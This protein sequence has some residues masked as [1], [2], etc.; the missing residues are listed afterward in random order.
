MARSDNEKQNQTLLDT[1]VLAVC[2]QEV[3]VSITR[4]VPHPKMRHRERRIDT[5]QIGS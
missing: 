2:T 5:W 4:F 3:V 1:I